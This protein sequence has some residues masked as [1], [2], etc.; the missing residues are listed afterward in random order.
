MNA[1]DLVAGQRARAEGRYEE[2]GEPWAF[3]GIVVVDQWGTWINVGGFQMCVYGD[4]PRSGLTSVTPLPAL[5]PNATVPVDDSDEA[6][7]L[8]ADWMQTYTGKRFYPTAPRQEDVDLNDIAHALSLLCR[9]NGHVKTFYSVAEHCV[10]LS[11]WIWNETLDA[12]LAR[13]ALL[14]DA[15]EAYIG[16]MI[17]PLKVHMPEFRAVDDRVTATI[18]AAFDLDGPIGQFGLALPD[19]VKHADTRIL[20][21]EKAALLSTP[22]GAWV[23]DELE[24]LGVPISGGW[25]P[26]YAEEQY[27]LCASRLGLGA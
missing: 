1:A 22:P 14:H 27:L 24:P 21:D 7:W 10:H 2:N 15:G 6:R 4:Q 3:E 16:D 18:A 11:R 20:L 12:N 25:T 23:V 8:R 9:Y 13:W 17:R 19:E 26:G 5:D